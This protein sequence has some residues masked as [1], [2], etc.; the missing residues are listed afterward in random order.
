MFD[1]SENTE[2]TEKLIDVEAVL[3]KHVPTLQCYPVPLRRLLI[4]G[5]KDEW[6]EPGV[7]KTLH[8]DLNIS[9][10]Y[11]IEDA[12]HC[13][14]ETHPE[15]VHRIMDKSDAAMRQIRESGPQ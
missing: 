3:F 11:T 7:G 13:P 5:L 15:Q 4:W 12:G 14:M 6:V 2:N 1:M 9:L 10:L 8:R